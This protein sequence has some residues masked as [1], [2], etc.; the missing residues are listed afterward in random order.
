MIKLRSFCSLLERAAA[1]VVALCLATGMQAFAFDPKIVEAAKKEGEVIWYTTLIV[2]Q[3]VR[4]I[5]DAFEK[6]YP[7]IRVRHVRSDNVGLVTRLLNEH[8]ANRPVADIVDGTSAELAL[9]RAGLIAQW[10]PDIAKVYPAEYKDANN[11]WVAPNLYFLTPAYNTNLI[12][13]GEHPKTFEDLLDPKLK[14]KMTW[15]IGDGS[16]GALGFIANVLRHMGKEKGMAYLERLSKQGIAAAEGSSR[17]VLD[18]TI[19]GEYAV[20]LQ[21]FHYHA[22]ISAKKGAPIEWIPMSPVMNV[23]STTSLMANAPHPNAGKLLFDFII[24]EEGQRLFQQNEYI[25]AYPN[26]DAFDKSLKPGKDTFH[27]TVF[28]QQDQVDRYDELKGIFDKLFR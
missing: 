25:P 4:P 6:K 26:M 27:A 11:R 24:S 8:R 2:N 7:G 16:S 14:G 22:L 15:N 3:I 1:G 5:T 17:A 21:I 10:V 12:K 23:Y 19:S 18:R 28:T 13:K 20:A 9:E